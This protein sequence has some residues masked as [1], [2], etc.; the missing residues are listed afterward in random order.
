[1]ICDWPCDYRHALI[2]KPN[3]KRQN[4]PCDLSE[5]L[6]SHLLH[7]LPS[8]THEKH[9]ITSIR[10]ESCLFI[11]TALNE[12][13]FHVDTVLATCLTRLNKDMFSNELGSCL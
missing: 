5:S 8:A 2:F 3:F 6:V 10:A 7:L 11:D 4:A 9:D 1:M 12:R 13:C